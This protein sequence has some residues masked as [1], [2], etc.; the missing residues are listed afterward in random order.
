MIGIWRAIRYQVEITRLL[1]D[2]FKTV[3][4]IKL[5]LKPTSV[6]K[7]II[8]GSVI[9]RSDFNKALKIRTS[10]IVVVVLNYFFLFLFLWC[11]TRS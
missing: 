9:L 2:L 11:K 10:S 7:K 6:I 4:K 1:L 5:V 8:S 3:L